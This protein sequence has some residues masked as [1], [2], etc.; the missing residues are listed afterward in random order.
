MCTPRYFPLSSVCVHGT[1]IP[2]ASRSAYCLCV[3]LDI[4]LD[5]TASAMASPSFLKL[6]N[7]PVV[8]WRQCL[9]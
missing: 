6:L 4:S 3:K 9:I 5:G 7:P 2:S 8:S 1:C